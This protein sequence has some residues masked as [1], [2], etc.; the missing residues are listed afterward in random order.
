MRRIN[1]APAATVSSYRITL[2]NTLFLPEL[3]EMLADENQAEL[4]E[5]CTALN[6]ARTAEFMEG[7][8]NNEIWRVLQYSDPQRRAEVFD[9]FDHNRKV[10]ILDQQPSGEVAALVEHLAED[11]RVDLLQDVDDQ[12]ADEILAL[13]PVVERRNILRLLSFPEGTAG[14]L[15]T[16]EVAKLTEGLTVQQAI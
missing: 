14:A 15:M 2:I 13:L 5:F 10:E 1:H 12:R 11:D 3:R 9:Y 4:E 7:L 8:A 6:P 16:T